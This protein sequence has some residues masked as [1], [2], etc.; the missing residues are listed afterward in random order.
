[1]AS[2]FWGSLI[3]SQDNIGASSFTSQYLNDIELTQY[4]N[5]QA[6]RAERARSS[7]SREIRIPADMP[8][9]ADPYGRYATIDI[10]MIADATANIM[11]ERSSTAYS[12]L[13][14]QV[15]RLK[16]IEARHTMEIQDLTLQL[17]LIRNDNSLLIEAIQI[18]TSAQSKRDIRQKKNKQRGAANVQN[19]RIS[20]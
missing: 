4:S 20:N 11:S 2:S 19:S 13:E 5:H 16:E 12:E 18:L 3:D 6:H 8:T 10:G 15:H 9:S 17:Q 1:M 14:Y 7:Y